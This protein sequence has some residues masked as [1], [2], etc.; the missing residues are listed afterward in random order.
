MMQIPKELRDAL[1]LRVGDPMEIF[2]DG[3]YVIF[4]PYHPG[5]TFCGDIDDIRNF[6]GRNVCP[7]CIAEL[8]D[9]Q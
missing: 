9:V 1:G 3:Q 6:R 2:V 8:E 5:C 7:K 4:R